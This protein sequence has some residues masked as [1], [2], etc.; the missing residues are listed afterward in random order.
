MLIFDPSKYY[1][2]AIFDLRVRILITGAFAVLFCLCSRLNPLVVG[3]FY[4]LVL[5]YA[6]RVSRAQIFR[7]LMAINFFMLMLFLF[8]PLS[9]TGEPVHA[10]TLAGSSARLRFRSRR[11]P[12]RADPRS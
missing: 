7:R 8:L 1:P 11:R 9:V 12:P 10:Q 5:T 6:G 4:A 3:L 2:L